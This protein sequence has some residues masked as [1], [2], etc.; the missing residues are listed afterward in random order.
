MNVQEF[1]ETVKEATRNV[2][3]NDPHTWEYLV[4]NVWEH[5]TPDFEP[6]KDIIDFFAKS[7]DGA[8]MGFLEEYLFDSKNTLKTDNGDVRLEKISWEG[9]QIVRVFSITNLDD[10]KQYFIIKGYCSSW[11][12]ET[13]YI[14]CSFV[15]VVPQEKT[16]IEYVPR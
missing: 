2:I 10:S 3:K 14:G 8:P 5:T 13:N 4:P 7:D 16:V 12:E 11:D 6:E 15:E 9:S 1:V